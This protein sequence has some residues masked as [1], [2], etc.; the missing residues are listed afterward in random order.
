MDPYT[1]GS[2]AAAPDPASHHLAAIAA[3]LTARGFA[4]ELTIL[5][6]TPVLTIEDPAAGPHP[7]TV[8][9]D[10]DISNGPGLPVDCT[11][12]WTPAPGTAPEATADTII[13]VLN[14]IR[15]ATNGAN[16]AD[17][18]VPGNDNPPGR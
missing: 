18:A 4:S 7:A 15:P 10:P 13:T 8:T 9:I 5:G 6:S 14:A 11:C 16:G 1:R 12:L 2:P 3:R 17:G